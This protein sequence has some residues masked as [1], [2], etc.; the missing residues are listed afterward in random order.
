MDQNTSWITPL[1]AAQRTQVT[2]ESVTRWCGRCEIGRK[3]AGRW[4]VDPAALDPILS[5][6]RSAV[7]TMPSA[8]YSLT[9]TFPVERMTLLRVTRQLGFTTVRLAAVD[10]MGLCVEEREGSLIPQV[11]ETVDRQ[12]RRWPVYAL[13]PSA[14]EAVEAAVAVQ[15]VQ[16]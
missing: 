15:W 4:R 7:A 10:L 1:Q 13:Q 9:P 14:C 8:P 16:S 3:M 12:G 5:G 6:S 11:P 2:S